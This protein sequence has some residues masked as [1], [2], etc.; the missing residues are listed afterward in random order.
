[1]ELADTL[2]K[3]PKAKKAIGHISEISL[4]LVKLF[5]SLAYSRLQKLR[6]VSF[7]AAAFA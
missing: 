2:I 6:Q 3:I 1:M 5:T 7:Y 4:F